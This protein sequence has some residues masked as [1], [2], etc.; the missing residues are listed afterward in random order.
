MDKLGC[1]D[2]EI[3]IKAKS[4]KEK[5]LLLWNSIFTTIS[6][7]KKVIIDTIDYDDTEYLSDH[8]LLSSSSITH[9]NWMDIDFDTTTWN[10]THLEG[11]FTLWWEIPIVKWLEK[12][13][14]VIQE[15]F[16]YNLEMS[17]IWESHTFKIS[18]LKENI[19]ASEIVACL[20]LDEE[21]M[22]KLESKN[23]IKINNFK[24]TWYTHKIMRFKASYFEKLFGTEIQH[25]KDIFMWIQNDIL[26]F[27]QP[28]CYYHFDFDIEN[29]CEDWIIREL[30]TTWVTALRVFWV[31]DNWNKKIILYTI[32]GYKKR[33][34]TVVWDAPDH[35]EIIVT[36]SI[37]DMNKIEN[38]LNTKNN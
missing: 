26:A 30:K 4:L 21:H 19:K 37:Y 6:D 34:W 18:D 25:W 11:Y 3:P 20:P 15:I 23:T 27:W 38:A 13:R 22:Y 24:D 8:A 2:R 14:T 7:V 36:R 32:H 35:D 9:E 10:S 29:E 16:W 5:F 31:D 28:Q 33:W 1:F 12:Y 17:V